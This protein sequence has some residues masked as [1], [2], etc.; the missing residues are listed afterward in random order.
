MTDEFLV[1]F[2]SF[3]TCLV[4]TPVV[5]RIALAVG[6]V[7]M[8]GERKI[9]L[10]PTP[11]LGGLA[12]YISFLFTV[13]FFHGGRVLSQSL[14]ILGG[15]TLVF[16][17]GLLDDWRSLSYRVRF[18]F[19]M[20]AASLILIVSGICA[21]V[22]PPSG[23]SSVINGFIT[24]L[25]VMGVTSAFSILDH[26]DGLCAGISAIASIFFFFFSFL[27]GQWLVSVLAVVIF[28]ASVGFL[29]WNFQKKIFMGSAGAMFLGFMMSVL[30]LKTDFSH[31]RAPACFLIP[32]LV[33]GVALF[34]TV[35]VTVSRV[36]RGLNPMSS[37]GKDHTA[38][39]LSRLWG[40]RRAVL[41]M[42]GCGFS[43]GV[44]SVVLSLMEVWQV[45]LTVFF[46]IL[47]FLFLLFFLEKIYYPQ[48]YYL[49]PVQ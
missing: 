28:G 19:V 1:V 35:L 23:V 5:R 33:L 9:H 29:V 43:L 12:I 49:K 47:L 34:D 39:R 45:Y 44:L 6:L 41:F 27:N 26:M 46:L 38:H 14:G 31:L 7:D 4:F 36:R 37:P 25:W 16:L 8:P 20:P 13:L 24:V 17:A 18:W 48:R 3:F 42:Y 40:E 2:F 22:L 15:G 21:P 10:V 30:G 32:V 11:L